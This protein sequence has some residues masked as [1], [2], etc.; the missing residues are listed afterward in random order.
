MVGVL[1]C[2]SAFAG[3][4]DEMTPEEKAKFLA[5]GQVTRSVPNPGSV[6]PEETIICKVPEDFRHAAALFTDYEAH[7]RCFP[8]VEMACVSQVVDSQTR[9]VDYRLRLPLTLG[10][11]NYTMEDRVACDDASCRVSWRLVRADTIKA[12][13]GSATFY[14]AGE[15]E[16]ILVYKSAVKPGRPGSRFF[17][18]QAA[19]ALR[20]TVGSFVP[21]LQKI[22]RENPEYLQG[23]VAEFEKMME[24]CVG[25][26][27]TPKVKKAASRKWLAG[28]CEML[29]KWKNR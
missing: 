18:R 26:S 12:S 2:L 21:Y 20:K 3:I 27:D 9:Q 28:F 19:G 7:P 11:E 29:E 23:R 13:Q 14:S 5:T 25:Q 17:V 16:S 24:G 22:Q 10:E 4:I 15:G 6:W 8:D 1:L